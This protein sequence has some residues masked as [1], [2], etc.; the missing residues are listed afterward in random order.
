MARRRIPENET[1]E[2]T[3][4]RQALEAVADNATRGEKVSWERKAD[5]MQKL[6]AD[7][8]PI[9]EQIVELMGKKTPIFDEIQNIRT[10]MVRDCVHPYEQL[11][12][13]STDDNK[14]YIL[15]K[16]CNKIFSVKQ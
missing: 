5:N 12:F 9:E 11:V 13:S 3:R 2:D 16:F 4:I 7:L 15:C 10:E 14:E 8:A 1:P 6:V